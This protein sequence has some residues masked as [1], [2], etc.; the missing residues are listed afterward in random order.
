MQKLIEGENKFIEVGKKD[1]VKVK[2]N[3]K[4]QES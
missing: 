2:T 4:D 1:T 3:P